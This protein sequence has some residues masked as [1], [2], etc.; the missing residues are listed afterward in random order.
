MNDLIKQIE[1]NQAHLQRQVSVLTNVVHAYQT[2]L[3]PP[4]AEFQITGRAVYAGTAQEDGKKYAAVRVLVP[5]EYTGREFRV[6]VIS[7]K[8]E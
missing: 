6:S 5:E 7:I 1:E 3:I 2:G 4:V 8:G